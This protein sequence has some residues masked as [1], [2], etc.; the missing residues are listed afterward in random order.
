MMARWSAFC[1]ATQTE[2][3]WEVFKRTAFETSVNDD[4][5]TIAELVWMQIAHTVMWKMRELEQ[6]LILK[7]WNSLELR[8]VLIASEPSVAGWGC[9]QMKSNLNGRSSN[10]PRRYWDD[11][12]D[13]GYMVV[14]PQ[15]EGHAIIT[16]CETD[17][18]FRL[19]EIVKIH[20]FMPVRT[21]PSEPL[22]ANAILKRE[23]SEKFWELN[24][25]GIC[26]SL[27]QSWS[28]PERNKVQ[29]WLKIRDRRSP[30][31]LSQLKK[32]LP[33]IL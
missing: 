10:Y 29:T 17:C 28:E 30:T 16:A 31:L 22:K 6:R 14:I 5:A 32:G 7:D 1:T 4:E 26:D 20:R 33:T 11:Y 27:Y 25:I 2:E 8:A 9:L 3:A 21:N 24:E 12:V 23:L 18:R 15:P 13:L 19:P